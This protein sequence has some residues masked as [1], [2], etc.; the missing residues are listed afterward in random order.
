MVTFRLKTKT[1]CTMYGICTVDD[2]NPSPHYGR[3]QPRIQTAVLGHSLVRSLV[4]SH[5]SLVGK[6]A[7]LSVF[8]PIFD[9]SELSPFLGLQGHLGGHTGSG[10]GSSNDNSY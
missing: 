1:P 7:I 6:M 4:R 2:I 3:E 5:R 8:F 9:H 10:I